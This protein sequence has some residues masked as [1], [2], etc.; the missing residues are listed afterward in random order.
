MARVRVRLFA[1]LREELGKKEIELEAR[2]VGDVVKALKI[3]DSCKVLIAVNHRL[4]DVSDAKLRAKLE[5]GD[6]VDL[7]PPFSGG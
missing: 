1:R 4:I 6:V 2:T 7:M 5:D 3:P